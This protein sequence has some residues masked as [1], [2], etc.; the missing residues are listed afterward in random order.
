MALSAFELE[1]AANIARRKDK[2]RELGLLDAAAVFNESIHAFKQRKSRSRAAPAPSRPLQVTTRAS[3]RRA[4]APLTPEGSPR[5]NSV[6]KLQQE[7]SGSDWAPTDSWDTYCSSFS[8]MD[9]EVPHTMD[10][11]MQEQA[12]QTEADQPE[13]EDSGSLADFLKQQ[14]DVV[15]PQ[16]SLAAFEREGMTVQHFLDRYGPDTHARCGR[17]CAHM[18]LHAWHSSALTLAGQLC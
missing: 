10:A 11:S 3:N 17:T 5:A 7:P 4:G 13:A 16:E 8:S 15:A 14:F 12:D 9:A 1:R 6:L 18:S 2:E